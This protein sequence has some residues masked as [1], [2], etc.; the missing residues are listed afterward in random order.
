M[1]IQEIEERKKE[2]AGKIQDTKSM[3]ELEELRSEVDEL[4]NA[5]PDEEEKP[6]EIEIQ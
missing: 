2:L 4:N 6:V 1:T 3:E 5:I